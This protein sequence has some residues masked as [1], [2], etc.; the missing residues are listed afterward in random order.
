M[1]GNV[2][3]ERS[4]RTNDRTAVLDT[5]RDLP[6]FA[7]LARAIARRGSLAVIQL[8]SAPSALS[9]RRQWSVNDRPAEATRLREI[10]SAFTDKE[11]SD[12]LAGFI[13]S[14]R[15]A[16]KAGYD[17]V[18]IHAAHGYLLSL[19][20]HPATNYRRGRFALYEKWFEEFVAEFRLV[21]G[22]SLCGIRL[23][24]ITGLIPPDS[25]IRH[26]ATISSI[27]V[28]NGIDIVDLSAGFYTV[29]RKLIYPGLEWTGP[30]YASWLETL[31]RDLDCLVSIAG[32]INDFRTLTDTLPANVL[33][34]M[35]RALIADPD[36]ASK[37]RD[38]KFDDINKCVL[39]NQC[40]YFSRGLQSLEC[41]VNP[42]L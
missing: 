17:V 20:L 3:I 40:H 5:E 11:L 39:K 4:S 31:A 2:A 7:V 19:L 28:A 16:V 12:H 1:V 27:A 25:E 26:T 41:G 32:R 38:G 14:A 42:N 33:V 15:F 13:R 23:S 8:A 30:I 6:R 37:S 29:D 34:S 36:F 24:V 9:P 22:E 35:G 10:V 21:L 18:Q